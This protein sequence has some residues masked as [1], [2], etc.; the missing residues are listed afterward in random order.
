M[1]YDEVNNIV[2]LNPDENWYGAD[3]LLIT[4]NDRTESIS[5][6]IDIVV[7]SVNDLPY[8][9]SAIAPLIL[10]NETSATL[11]ISNS[12]EDVDSETLTISVQGTANIAVAA[13]GTPG[14]FQLTTSE[15]W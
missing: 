14:V 15:G 6:E 1:T 10:N 7:S 13:T 9:K 11:D 2:T 5:T 3:T 8:L 12:F 4:A